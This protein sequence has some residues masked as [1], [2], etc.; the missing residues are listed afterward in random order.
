MLKTTSPT[1]TID[2]AQNEQYNLILLDEDTAD[3]SPKLYVVS[4]R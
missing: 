2:G 4:W 3:V 1:Y